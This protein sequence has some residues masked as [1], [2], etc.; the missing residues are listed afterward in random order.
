MSEDTFK[1]E[2]NQ[3]DSLKFQAEL[4]TANNEWDKALEFY[5][6]ALELQPNNPDSLVNI[7][8]AYKALEQVN[9][10]ENYYLQALEFDSENWRALHNLGNLYKDFKKEYTTAIRY[11][12][13][14]LKTSSN[15][16]MSLNGL[17]LTYSI[18]GD[19]EKTHFYLQKA[20]D[21]NPTEP[22]L[23]RN[24]GMQLYHHKR[25]K[26]AV[27][28]LVGVV[29]PDNSAMQDILCAISDSHFHLKNWKNAIEFLTEFLNIDHENTWALKTR[30]E[31]YV[32]IKEY[33]LALND[34]KKMI[35]FAPSSREALSV[36]AFIYKK[37]EEFISEID[38]YD[39]L[40]F[41]DSCNSFYHFQKAISYQNLYEK[42]NDASFLEQSLDSINQAIS[43]APEYWGNYYIKGR[44]Y[45]SCGK[46]EE[47]LD[48]FQKAISLDSRSGASFLIAADVLMKLGKEE[49]S[50]KYKEQ[51]EKLPYF[52]EGR[53]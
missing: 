33:A 22:K 51:G 52:I 30:A 31:A 32:Q 8:N 41:V 48:C 11:Y 53:I 1:N 40:I 2:M 19:I 36:M 26:S 5:K 28:V 7:G 29:I 34:C 13:K 18:L 39:N 4:A 24:L 6:Q 17:G 35:D 25:Y 16:Y 23:R 45:F 42:T 37:Q 10:A 20:I 44:S 38:V 21:L 14:A 50:N 27:E 46:F 9:K 49:E 12:E 43:L 47:S 3:Y 15:P